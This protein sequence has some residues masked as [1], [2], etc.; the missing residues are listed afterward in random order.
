MATD[1][2]RPTVPGSEVLGDMRVAP[3]PEGT[4]AEALFMLVKLDDGNWCARSVG[5][6]AYN[7][8]E[9]LGQLTAYTY[10]L[11]V[12]EAEGWFDDEDPAT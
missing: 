5:G 8:V 3:L 11:K 12:S 6:D 1:E 2:T 4:R 7:R 9:F 10:G